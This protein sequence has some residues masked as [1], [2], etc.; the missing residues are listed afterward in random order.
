MEPIIE[1]DAAYANPATPNVIG[2]ATAEET[3][4]ETQPTVRTQQRVHYG[5]TNVMAS[6]L[7]KFIRSK[8]DL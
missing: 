4:D 6:D 7:K 3:K 2:N 5:T 1:V 8:D